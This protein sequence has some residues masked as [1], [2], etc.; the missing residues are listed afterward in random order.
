MVGSSEEISSD[1]NEM[2]LPLTAAFEL[3]VSKTTTAKME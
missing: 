1:D 2:E 3:S